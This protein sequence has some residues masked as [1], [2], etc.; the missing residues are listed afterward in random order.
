[1]R[2]YVASG[3]AGMLMVLAGCSHSSPSTSPS[4]S[5]S[6]AAESTT[7]SPAEAP[8]QGEIGEHT[9][10]IPAGETVRADLARGTVYRAELDGQN[11]GLSIR[12]IVASMQRPLVEKMFAG[13]SASGTSVYTITCYA[14]GQYEFYTTGGALQPLTL[15]LSF[16]KNFKIKGDTT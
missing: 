8:R 4:T 14:T 6:P 5:P 3:V 1:M 9:F 16:V 12:P 15:H 11:V 10:T 13:T 2:K 7:S